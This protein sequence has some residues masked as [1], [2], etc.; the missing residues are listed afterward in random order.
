MSY[1]MLDSVTVRLIQNFKNSPKIGVKEIFNFFW[2]ITWSGSWTFIKFQVQRY[3]L[4]SL[5]A[6]RQQTDR[7]TDGAANF[8]ERYMIPSL[9]D[10]I[11]TQSNNLCKRTACRLED[12]GA[13]QMGHTFILVLL[14]DL[15]VLV[16]VIF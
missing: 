16:N 5:G 1:A 13:T 14:R 7:R 15:I 9:R 10:L 8:L 4:C 11:N 6:F 3:C 12:F 2:P